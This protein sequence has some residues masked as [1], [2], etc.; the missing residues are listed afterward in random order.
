MKRLILG[1]LGA[2]AL[3]GCGGGGGGSSTKPARVAYVNASPDAGNLDFLL[4]SDTKASAVSFGTATAFANVKPADYDASILAT[5]NPEI[6]WSEAKTFTANSDNLVVAVGLANPDTSQDTEQ[7]KRILFTFAGID[8]S[9]PTGNRARLII[10][11]AFV[12]QVGFGTP[13]IDFK[14]PGDNPVVGADSANIAF[15]GTRT[16]VVDSGAQ[17]FQIRQNG[18]D[19]VFMEGTFTLAPSSVYLALVS[20]FEGTAGATAPAIRLIPLPTH[21][22]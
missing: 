14:G 22:D 3:F 6:L 5:G 16:I 7:D 17:T 15:G 20:G 19:Q 18:T 9:V 1:V 21:T 10:V 8:R 4:D 11:H 12:R 13:A 2:L